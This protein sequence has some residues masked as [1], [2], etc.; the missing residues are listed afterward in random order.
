ML[1]SW[2]DVFAKFWA[3]ILNLW[4][5]CMLSENIF[6]QSLRCWKHQIKHSN[7]MK[8]ICHRS[9]SGSSGSVSLLCQD[10]WFIWK[11][12]W[13][14]SQDSW[15]EPHF[16]E[17]L[18]LLPLHFKVLGNKETIRRTLLLRYWFSLLPRH[19]ARSVSKTIGD[20]GEVLQ[21][22]SYMETSALPISVTCRPFKRIDE[23]ALLPH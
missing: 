7:I 8:V 2:S 19:L 17:T 1:W 9:Y 14:L 22:S 11:L 10:C 4:V 18:G 21:K 20:F 15:Q 5:T 3:K 6:L 12:L 16:V 13:I 23:T